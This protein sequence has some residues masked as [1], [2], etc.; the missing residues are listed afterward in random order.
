MNRPRYLT[1]I[2][3]IAL[4]A[5]PMPAQEKANPI[6][7][8]KPET[9]PLTKLPPAKVRPN[10]CLLTYRISTRSPECQAHFDQGLGYFYN[11][12][13]MEAA[14]S[15]ETASKIDPDCAM[16]WWGLSRALEE[17]KGPI[18]LEALKTAQK[19][20]PKA[21]DRELRLIA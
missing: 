20:L 15:F 11:Y 13:W 18:H 1:A 12:V 10:Q 2:L 7:P 3:F 19:L 8:A 9:L 5:A 16:A 14:R 4:C 6:P 21:S 17:W